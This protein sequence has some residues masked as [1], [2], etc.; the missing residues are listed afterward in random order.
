MLIDLQGL[1][2]RSMTQ[3]FIKIIITADSMLIQ[4]FDGL[5]TSLALKDYEVS[6]VTS[7][8]PLSSSIISIS[9]GVPR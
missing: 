2:H 4:C 9:V 7:Q 5:K 8:F 6:I 1:L 3:Q